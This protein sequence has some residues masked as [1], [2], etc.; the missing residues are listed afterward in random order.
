MP[1]DQYNLINWLSKSIPM[2]VGRIKMPLKTKEVFIILITT[3]LILTACSER[4]DMPKS[5][6]VVFDVMSFWDEVGQ[7]T[8]SEAELVERLGEPERIFEV[9][10]ESPWDVD[11]FINMKYLCYEKNKESFMGYSYIYY[12]NPNTGMLDLITI[13][14][15]EIPYLNEE[16]ILPMFNLTLSPNSE[17]VDHGARQYRVYDCGVRSFWVTSMDDSYL[18]IIIIAYTEDG[19]MLSKI[20]V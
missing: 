2:G 7:S 19:I 20:K 12:F 10:Y 11:E 4:N 3:V 17:V 15:V 18:K 6:P 1:A 8:I 16:Y 5:S 9:P 13:G 14:G